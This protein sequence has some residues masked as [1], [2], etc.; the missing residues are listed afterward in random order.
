MPL[1]QIYPACPQPEVLNDQVHSINLAAGLQIILGDESN[2]S[3]I[4][5]YAGSNPPQNQQCSW[6]RKV[7]AHPP[8]QNYTPVEVTP[9]PGEVTCK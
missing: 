5:G 8:F 7:A 2:P 9:L 6:V 4:L 1:S 3:T